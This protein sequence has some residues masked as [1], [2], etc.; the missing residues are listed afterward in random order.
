MARLSSICFKNNII[1]FLL[2]QGKDVVGNKC[3]YCETKKSVFPAV[4]S[5]LFKT[6]TK[7]RNTLNFYQFRGKFDLI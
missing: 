7:N 1:T 4:L 3:N 5:G 6:L 2:I